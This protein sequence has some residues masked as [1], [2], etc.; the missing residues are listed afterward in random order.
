MTLQWTKPKV[1]TKEG[2]SYTVSTIEM[3]SIF[4]GSSE[5]ISEKSCTL[6]FVFIIKFSYNARSHWL[7]QWALS[8]NRERVKDIKLAF[9]FLLWNF[10]KLNLRCA[11]Q[12]KSM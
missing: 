6:L 10:D 9:K 12:T 4:D 3:S 5:R 2:L 8:G 11:T 1:T 7:K